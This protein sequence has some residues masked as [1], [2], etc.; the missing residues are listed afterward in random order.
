MLPNK[1]KGYSSVAG[2]PCSQVAPAKSGANFLHCKRAHTCSHTHACVH[3]K[4]VFLRTSKCLTQSG[5]L[6]NHG[7]LRAGW[8]LLGEVC[9]APEGLLLGLRWSRLEL[10]AQGSCRRLAQMWRSCKGREGEGDTAC[11]SGMHSTSSDSSCEDSYLC[12]MQGAGR[13]YT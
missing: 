4:K 1:G 11:A 12:L 10:L 5:L 2:G 13:A 7:K 9:V 8:Q 3:A 6:L